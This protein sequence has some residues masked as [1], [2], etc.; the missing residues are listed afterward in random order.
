MNRF[1]SDFTKGLVIGIGAIAP[2]VSGG[3]LAVIFGIYEEIT[4]AIAHIFKDFK[5][6]V[7]YFFPLALGGGI[8]FLGFSRII[9][10]LFKYYEVEVKYLFIGLMIGTLPSVLKQANKHGFKRKYIIPFILT[11]GITVFFVV[12]ENTTINIVPEGSPTAVML[13]VYGAILGFGTMI[14]GISASFILMYLGGYQVMLEGISNIDLAILI[15][16][17]VGF[18]LSIIAFAKLISMLF[19]RA[20]SYTYFGVLGFAL[21]SIIT[22]YPGI[23]F[24][25]KYFICL[26]LFITGLNLSLWLSRYEKNN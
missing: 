25:F 11:L 23:G 26:L 17:G 1:I 8:G 16:V 5:K 18:A 6:K 14:P 22:I 4:D 21:G 15:P 9:N 7:I 3:T 10:Y 13:A 2:G 12:L 24:N 20:Y 19:K